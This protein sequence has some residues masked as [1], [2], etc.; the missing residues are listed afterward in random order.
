MVE[1]GAAHPARCFR[2]ASAERLAA[3]EGVG[4]QAD[5]DRVEA[6]PG[7]PAERAVPRSPRSASAVGE[8][9]SASR[10]GARV[11]AREQDAGADVAPAARSAAAAASR[12]RGRAPRRAPR[13]RRLRAR[14]RGASPPPSRAASPS[15]ASSSDPAVSATIRSAKAPRTT[16]MP[17][18]SA[19][20]RVGASWLGQRAD[21]DEDHGDRGDLEGQVGGGPAA[22]PPASSPTQ[23]ASQSTATPASRP[24]RSRRGTRVAAADG[25]GEDDL[26]ATRVLLGAQRPHRGEDAPDGG[27]EREHAADPP[28]DVA[29]D[30]EQVVGDAVEEAD[31]LVVAEAAARTAAARRRSG[32]CVRSRPPGPARAAPKR[33]AK[34]SVRVRAVGEG[35][36][37]ASAL[38]AP[39]RRAV[40]AV[41]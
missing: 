1:R 38:V 23:V 9:R 12:Q 6:D 5:D 35:P 26:P 8:E 39:S 2:A 33:S 3:A 17:A 36:R 22:R 25:A 10:G 20:R 27:E 14:R 34:E 7:R 29:A 30:R 41:S 18:P 31:R 15:A 16:A 24:R 28:G 4:E 13:R 21:A 19:S 32:S 40:V 11:G 37:R